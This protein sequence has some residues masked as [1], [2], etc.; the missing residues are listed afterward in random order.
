MI[1]YIGID[2]TDNLNTRGTGF[3]ARKLGEE[4][5]K[6]DLGCLLGISRHQL[7]VDP[8]IPYT[9][10]NSSLCLELDAGENKMEE[11]KKLC[12]AFLE[13]ESAEGSDPGLCIVKEAELPKNVIE[14]GRKAKGEVLTKEEAF[15][16][17]RANGIHLSEHG[18]TGGGI[19][20]SL[21][22]VGL[23]GEGNDGRFVW[24][25]GIR[26]M[27]G[28]YTAQQILEQSG[29]KAIQTLNGITPQKDDLINVGDWFRPV[30]LNGV[31]TLIIKESKDQQARWAII[32][33]E[34][35][36]ANH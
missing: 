25:K 32:E 24:L 23:R 20:G 6:K 13:A 19:I 31:P 3:R 35:I 11:I 34:Y 36:K 1:I 12:I 27:E 10:H 16:L 2:D 9:S 4:L 30:L 28:I 26:E 7:F 22:G 33:R 17:A 8:A 15:S 5:V 14:F 18:G 21:A 29:I